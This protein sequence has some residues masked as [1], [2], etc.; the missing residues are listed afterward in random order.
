MADG[1][2]LP[3]EDAYGQAML[4]ALDGQPAF[5]VV[6]RDDGYVGLGRDR[7]CI[8]LNTSNGVR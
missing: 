1:A 6:E 2:L 3:E 7:S 8:S 4:D 5:E